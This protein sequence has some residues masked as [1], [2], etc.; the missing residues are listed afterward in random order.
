MTHTRPDAPLPSALTPQ[1]QRAL[2]RWLDAV[3]EDSFPA[4]DPAPLTRPIYD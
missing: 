4:S 2:D 3:L 1:T